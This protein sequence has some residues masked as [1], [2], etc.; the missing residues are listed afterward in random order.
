MGG[1]ETYAQRFFVC[2]EF[3]KGP[4][5]PIFFYAGNEADVTL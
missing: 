1:R 2:K 5:G 4:S 3:W